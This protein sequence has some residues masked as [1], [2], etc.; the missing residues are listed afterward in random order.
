TILLKPARP[1]AGSP[2]STAVAGAPGAPAGESSGAAAA[3]APSTVSAA[4]GQSDTTAAHATND[5]AGA[6]DDTVRVSSPIYTYGI[7]TRGGRLVEIRLPTYRSM[8]RGE[9]NRE[10]QL[11][12]QGS[13]IMDLMVVAGRDSFPLR[14]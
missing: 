9:T 2:D 14:T 3:A 7:S 1:P 11:V 4:P 6:R 10:V 5:P 12:P 13:S 8:A